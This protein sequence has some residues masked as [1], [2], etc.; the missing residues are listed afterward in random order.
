MLENREKLCESVIDVMQPKNT[1]VDEVYLADRCK[2]R[3]LTLSD[4]PELRQEAI[5]MAGLAELVDGYYVE[6]ESVQVQTLLFTLEGG[7]ILTTADDVILLEPFSL[8]VIPANT[9]FRFELN[10]IDNHWKMIWLLLEADSKWDHF[11]KSNLTKSSFNKS[12]LNKQVSNKSASNKPVPSKP[13]PSKLSIKVI[14]Y[15]DVERLWSLLHLIHTEIG[16]RASFRRLLVSEFSRLLMGFEQPAVSSV[17]R[18]HA[19]FNDIEGQLHL[20]WTVKKMAKLCFISEEQLN[21]IS[22]QLFAL[23]PRSKLIQLRME[24]AADL[25]QYREWNI[26]MISHRLGYKDPYN[27]THRF[28]KHFGCSPSRYRKLLSEQEV[29]VDI[30]RESV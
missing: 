9:P 4:I 28:R 5:F 14:P 21:R 11:S 17:S 18:V 27:F 25:L 23:S 7:G 30:E 6:R 24:K 16:A 1:W 13:V 10:P 15:H 12:S 29:R 2:E 8:L 19:L 22:K 26:T 3:F 20:N